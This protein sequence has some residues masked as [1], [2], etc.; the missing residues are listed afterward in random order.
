MAP[1][2]PAWAAKLKRRT[3]RGGDN[4]PNM[5]RYEAERHARQAGQVLLAAGGRPG[6]PPTD[7]LWPFA[8]AHCR[9]WHLTRIAG[10]SA[11]I[12][13]TAMFEGIAVQ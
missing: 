11:A 2:L 7:R 10:R 4:C 13:A 3:A 6:H 1:D 8:C 5:A 12:T 9:G